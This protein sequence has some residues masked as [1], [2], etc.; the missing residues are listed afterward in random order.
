VLQTTFIS[1]GVRRGTGSGGTVGTGAVVE[2]GVAVKIA[3]G[4][5]VGVDVHACVAVGV[6]VRV[7][8]G[9][10]VKVVVGVVV[11]VGV[12]VAVGV[13]V[14][15]AVLATRTVLNSISSSKALE[16]PAYWASA[17]HDTETDTIVVTTN[18]R[19]NSRQGRAAPKAFLGPHNERPRS[20]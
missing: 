6:G 1:R 8:V 3:A 10:T 12:R 18:N 13:W 19:S 14:G 15:V 5:L 9:V 11:G 2:T 4:V 16:A 17:S 7:A 20:P